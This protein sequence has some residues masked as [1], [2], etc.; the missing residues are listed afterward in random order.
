[1]LKF[2]MAPTG[3]KLPHCEQR[4]R[5]HVHDHPRV[6]RR[7][8]LAPHFAVESALRSLTP[9]WTA[10]SVD[11]RACHWLESQRTSATGV[12]RV[13]TVTRA[14]CP[15]TTQRTTTNTRILPVD[16]P[17]QLPLFDPVRLYASTFFVTSACSLAIIAACL[18]VPVVGLAILAF[19]SGW[20]E[21]DGGCGMSHIG[22]M[23]PLWK[24]NPES[25]WMP[26]SKALIAYTMAGVA[27]A[28]LVGL[29]VEVCGQLIQPLLPTPVAYTCAVL[30]SLGLVARETFFP[31][32]NLPQIR[33]QTR[34]E[35]VR[36][37]GPNTA[38][39]MW[40]AHIGLGFATVISHGGIF[41][42]AF[43][44]VTLPEI[45]WTVFVS[46]WL[47][48]TCPIWLAPVAPEVDVGKLIIRIDSSY[49]QLRRSAILIHFTIA[50][51]I[52]LMSVLRMGSSP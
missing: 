8:R 7:T 11:T 20:G 34:P 29:F 17:G 47:G 49:R 48:R 39:G 10:R 38:A 27:T 40:G 25:R 43:A 5:L 28:G 24:S 33:R 23:R 2:L 30:L 51:V 22:A 46:F 19:L 12:S 3:A 50:L 14:R 15:A 16:T 1:M 36:V 26:W 44:I 18:G 21:L 35:W 13:S 9:C 52:A 42:I 45:T 41:P 37:F 31:K 32:C 4:S 6:T